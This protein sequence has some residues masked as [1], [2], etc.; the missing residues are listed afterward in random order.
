MIQINYSNPSIFIL[1]EAIGLAQCDRHLSKDRQ[2]ILNPV[3][4]D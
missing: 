1:V 4:K 2:V 3:I